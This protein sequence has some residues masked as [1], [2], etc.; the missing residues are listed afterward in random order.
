MPRVQSS[1]L[2]AD[3]MAKTSN[4]EVI[5]SAMHRPI[6]PREACLPASPKSPPWEPP[7]P[8][9]V[10]NPAVP[11]LDWLRRFLAINP[12]Y[13]ASAAVLLYGIYCISS[14]AG[15]LRIEAHQLFFNFTALQFY[16]AA[17][18]V[19]A[20]FLARRR[21]W[22]DSTLLV[23]LENLVI[24]VPFILITQ[25]SLIEQGWMRG[26]VGVGVGLVAARTCVLR[27]W[28]PELNLPGRTLALGG[29]LLAVNVVLPIVYRN[30]QEE[31]VAKT[32][33]WGPAYQMNEWSWL[34][35][36]PLLV[37]CA[38]LLPAPYSAGP[39][40]GQRRWLPS[41]LFFSWAF[42]SGV[43]LYALSY[44]Y[45]FQ[46]RA[47]LWA[48][49][50]VVLAWTLRPRLTDWVQRPGAGVEIA[51][52]CLPFP[53]AFLALCSG[54]TGVSLALLGLNAGLYAWTAIRGEHPKLA[55]QLALA[56]GVAALACVPAIWNV[57]AVI[58]SIHPMGFA[59]TMTVYVVLASLFSRRPEMGLLGAVSVGVG[60]ARIIPVMPVAMHCAFHGSMMFLLL[61]S[62][63]WD[64][65][66]EASAGTLRWITAILWVLHA[67]LWTV[68]GGPAWQIAAVGAGV[69]LTWL[70]VLWF[71]RV[72][73]PLAV[74]VAGSAVASSGPGLQAAA[75]LMA[76]PVGLL[77]VAA[78][79]VLLAV[80]TVTALTK[81]RWHRV[82]RA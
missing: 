23:L 12:F 59:E 25:A 82:S 58:G 41:V 51:M 79:F 33:T 13:L 2:S 62:L 77:A 21:L 72:R 38:N 61:H 18:V 29:V 63:R 14:E 19:L 7:V 56:S 66:R 31:R 4:P 50:L 45:T 44:V 43:H 49:M 36:L 74:V 60:L 28:T 76:A 9:P 53:F 16:E 48:P 57:P 17:L 71:R 22:Y 54:D 24:I 46:L 55:G 11:P 42:A 3:V 34:A 69:V 37:A 10:G 78:S 39:G 64:D 40:R 6:L 27:R 47:A 35:I 1:A 26:L 80:G 8:P 81:H 68:T 75:W 30:L 65:A 73:P 5:M 67:C 32:I 20:V 70:A 52:L 15:F